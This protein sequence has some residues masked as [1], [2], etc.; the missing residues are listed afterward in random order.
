MTRY[1]AW[2]YD[3]PRSI[4]D[5]MTP[6]EFLLV[7]ARFVFQDQDVSSF[8]REFL[9]ESIIQ[10]SNNL[11]D[12]NQEL[13]DMRFKAPE[14]NHVLSLQREIGRLKALLEETK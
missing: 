13:N 12:A 9:L 2:P 8:D 7:I 5:E 14:N 1:R 10:M 11:D 4:Y 3:P 6:E